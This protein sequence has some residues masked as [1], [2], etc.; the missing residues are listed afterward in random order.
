MQNPGPYVDSAAGG[1]YPRRPNRGGV[2]G[3]A[4]PRGQNP[5]AG[6]SRFLKA[7]ARRFG[8]DW[9][10]EDDSNFSLAD[11]TPVPYKKS[12]WPPKYKEATEKLIESAGF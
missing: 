7:P 1:S 8:H 3:E 12:D 6:V 5:D 11:Q 9:V 4:L 10:R 2:E